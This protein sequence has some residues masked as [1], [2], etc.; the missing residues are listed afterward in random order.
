MDHHDAVRLS[1]V[2]KYLLD[3]L[4]PEFRDEFEEHY[5]D[6]QECA[7]DLRATAA[8]VDAAKKELKAFPAAKPTPSPAKKPRLAWLWAPAFVLP[9]L[10]ACL[11]VIAYQNF[12]VFPH[13]RSALAELRTPEILPSVSLVGGNSRGGQTPSITVH[14]AQPFLVLV[15]IPPQDRF[16]SYT[17]LLYSPSGSLVWRVQVSAQL[18]KDTVS[19]RV[20]PVN[21][22]AGSYTLMVQGNT[23]RTPAETGVDLGHYRFTLNTQ[24]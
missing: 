19:I 6:C 13:F 3:E 22:M 17:C 4:P 15:D 21:R 16:S 11:L 10:A 8:F 18:A 14:G 9:A 20:P 23:D 24:N 1:L 2:E 12:V 7:A 5:F